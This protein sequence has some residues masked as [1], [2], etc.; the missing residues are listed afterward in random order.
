[1]SQAIAAVGQIHLAGEFQKLFDKNKI[2]KNGIS[3]ALT[4]IE[5]TLFTFLVENAGK[6]YN[7]I[8]IPVMKG[9]LCEPSAQ[10]VFSRGKDGKTASFS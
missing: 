8:P 4:P 9:G 6:S 2:I 10:S 3:I 5:F 7:R 1:M